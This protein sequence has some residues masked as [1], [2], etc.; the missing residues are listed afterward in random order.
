[1]VVYDT[2]GLGIDSGVT[3]DGSPTAAGSGHIFLGGCSGFNISSRHEGNTNGSQFITVASQKDKDGNATLGGIAILSSQGGAI[4]GVSATSPGGVAYVIRLDGCQGISV[5]ASALS[6]IT[7]A[8]VYLAT[9]TINNT[10][11]GFSNPGGL[12]V[13]QT[14]TNEHNNDVSLHT[15]MTGTYTPSL[16]S[17]GAEVGRTYSLRQGRWQRI[18][19]RV[20]FEVEITLSAK[21]SSTG[22]T[23]VTLPFNKAGSALDVTPCAVWNSRVTY[24]GQVA[25][26]VAGGTTR[27]N[28]YVTASGAAALL[29]Q[30]TG[31]ADNSY[32]SFSGHYEV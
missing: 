13:F 19:N 17:D 28:V 32:L 20:H 21:G 26:A 6:G 14:A 9:G 5:V 11:R 15:Y 10:I 18:G 27:I 1:V 30:D 23:Q 22:S 8:L 4:N 29:L 7:T 25:A 24:T 12:A 16:L 31:L 3:F 2:N